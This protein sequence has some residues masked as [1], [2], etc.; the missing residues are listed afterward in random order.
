[1]KPKN[2]R[3]KV[4]IVT[5]GMEFCT[6]IKKGGKSISDNKLSKEDKELVGDSALGVAHYYESPKFKHWEKFIIDEAFKIANKQNQSNLE[7][8]AEEVEIIK[9]ALCWAIDG[10]KELS[11]T[12]ALIEFRTL[13]TRIKEWQDEPA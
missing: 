3:L 13:L 11:N 8:T 10:A 4:C 2:K 5:D 9:N 1:M 7:L 6:Y 12:E